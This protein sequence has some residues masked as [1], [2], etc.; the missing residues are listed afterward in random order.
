MDDLVKVDDLLVA[1]DAF[2]REIAAADSVPALAELVRKADSLIGYMRSA[3]RYDFETVQQFCFGRGDAVRRAGG[4][5]E[6]IAPGSGRGEKNRN[7]A[8]SYF[9][10]IKDANI[11]KDTAERWRASARFPQAK[12]EAF[13]AKLKKTGEL[14]KLTD[15]YRLG[16]PAQARSRV[17]DVAD[18]TG[19]YP[20]I[21]ADPPWQYELPPM[22]DTNR[23]IEA[24]YPTMT[25]DSIK[26]ISV[27]ATNDAVLFLWATAPKLAESMEVVE[28]WGFDYRT[29]VVWVK[30]KIGMGYYVRNQHELLLIGRRGNMPLPEPGTQPSS[31][32]T[33]PRT[34]H[35]VQLATERLF[36]L[37][38]NPFCNAQEKRRC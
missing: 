3:G 23:S 17:K 5:L 37:V 33:A 1:P 25:L 15:L 18:A 27:P 2:A 38:C 6:D 26:N 13:K 10:Q 9:E 24:H 19:Q 28:A 36:T 12:Y 31:V 35:S 20:V 21:Y 11:K 16:K 7:A 14:L 34:G 29:N 22:G 30:D 4:M 32:I 8:V